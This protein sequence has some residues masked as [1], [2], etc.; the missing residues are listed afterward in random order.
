LREADA[1][2]LEGEMKWPFRNKKTEKKS[3]DSLVQ[4]SQGIYY[5]GSSGSK[6]QRLKDYVKGY[7]LCDTVYSCVN[8]I[9]QSAVLVPWYVY[10][11][12]G[13]D[14]E[15]IEKHPLIDFMDHPG[16]GMD[17]TEYLTRSL[18]FFLT[19]GNA[20]THKLIGSFGK[21]GQIEVLRPQL[22]TIKADKGK[23]TAYE[24]RIGG[25]LIIFPPEE[26]IHVKTFHPD[27]PL[28]GLSPLQVLAKKIDISQFGELWTVA[29]LE[30]EARPSGALTIE[31]G[32]SPDQRDKLKQELKDEYTG[33]QNAGK[34]LMLEGGWKWQSFAITP[35]EMEFLNS[36][37]IT[38]REIC[39]A[40]KV[41]PELFGDNENKTYSNIKEARKALYQEAVLPLLGKFKT[42]LNRELVP[43]FDANGVYLD[44]DVSGIDALSEDLDSL[45]ERVL[46]A[47]REGTITRGEAREEMG[48]GE[49]P[50]EDVITEG[51]AVVSTP[52]SELG[53]EPEP[54]PAPAPVKPAIEEPPPKSATIMVKAKGPLFWQN[55]QR[56]RAKWDLFH[57]NVKAR[58][59]SIEKIAKE[60]L[61]KQAEEIIDAIKKRPGLQYVGF[62]ILNVKKESERFAAL[63]MPWAVDAAKHG[64]NSGLAA[65]RGEL[66]AA[67]A[68]GSWTPE[69]EKRVR[70]M[71]LKSGA[72]ITEARL[73][74][75]FMVLDQSQ[76]ENWTY[77]QFTQELASRFKDK[78]P[79]ECRRIAL[80]ESAKVENYGELEGYKQTE[81][82]EFKGWLCSFLPLSRESHIK[83]D[84]DYRDNP[85]PLEQDFIVDEEGLEFPSDPKGSPGNIINCHCNLYP[86]VREA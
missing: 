2:D 61:H 10:R 71:V 35:K 62:D 40:Y 77:E 4:Y 69:N 22:M 1:D 31:Q 11:D 75:I 17:W 41:A 7:E 27:D 54:A 37:K 32:L 68:G 18:S 66:E 13:D 34:P 81:F 74:E 8:M 33:Y 86:S 53:K 42:A 73:R 58:G 15:E 43:L 72:K 16:P 24:Y 51:I 80:T 50:G 20:Y 9:V 6:N 44:Y 78:L 12:K 64:I 23:I 48:Y 55:P 57:A 25:Q 29:L 5:L 84:A 14:V 39:A 63:A 45:W 21:Y 28:Y 19:V 60:F 76:V 56:K 85:I 38:M 65:A 67:K 36:K 83:A 3:S 52:V 46:N 82:I 59:K 30:N 79:W 47:K 49:L 70:D 26:I